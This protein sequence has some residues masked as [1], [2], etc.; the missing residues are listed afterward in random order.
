MIIRLLY[1][2]YWLVLGIIIYRYEKKIAC[3]EEEN[4]HVK[5]LLDIAEDSALKR[6]EKLAKMKK[7][8]GT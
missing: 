6:Q 2:T 4:R 7:W 5:A 1:L 8:N 3:L